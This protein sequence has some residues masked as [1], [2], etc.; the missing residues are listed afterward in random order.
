M[1]IQMIDISN[2][3]NTLM[4]LSLKAKMTLLNMWFSLI[5]FLTSSIEIHVLVNSK[6]YGILIVITLS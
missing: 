6:I 4:I 5:I 1:S 3:G 2:F